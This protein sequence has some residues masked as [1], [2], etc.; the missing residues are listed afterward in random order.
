MVEN[1]LEKEGSLTLYSL[2]PLYEPFDVAINEIKE[3]WKFVNFISNELPEPV[4]P[5]NQLVRTV[6]SLKHDI[7]KIKRFMPEREN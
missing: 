7:D 4:L 6:A 1:N 3:V 5:E 2:N